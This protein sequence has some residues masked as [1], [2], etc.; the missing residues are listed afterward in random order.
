MWT[1]TFFLR[2]KF[3]G[4]FVTFGN[5][6]LIQ[7][8]GASSNILI[9]SQSKLLYSLPFATTLLW[10]HGVTNKTFNYTH[11]ILKRK[12]KKNPFC[13]LLTQKREPP[14]VCAIN[15][16]AYF[17]HYR[18][19][20]TACNRRI[21]NHARRKRTWNMHANRNRHSLGIQQLNMFVCGGAHGVWICALQVTW[22]NAP[23]HCMPTQRLHTY[24]SLSFFKVNYLS[25]YK[26]I[27]FTGTDGNLIYH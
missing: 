21:L 26:E 7:I 12:K 1:A 11:S 10:V 20:S 16:A 5:V 23:I 22:A 15:S 8:F 9:I 3:Y 19:C 24:N 4:G 25:A 17:A 18:L 14:T 6:P 13:I 27:Y 2:S